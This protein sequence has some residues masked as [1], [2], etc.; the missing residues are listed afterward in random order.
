MREDFVKSL[1]LWSLELINR[2]NILFCNGLP[3]SLQAIRQL[4]RQGDLQNVIAMWKLCATIAASKPNIS[5][6]TMS[7]SRIQRPAARQAALQQ[8]AA[9]DAL[10]GI[11]AA[12]FKEQLTPM[13]E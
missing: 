5:P 10:V 11:A 13:A 3:V 9:L 2:I 7:S 12:R 1:I 6:S 4:R 8:Q